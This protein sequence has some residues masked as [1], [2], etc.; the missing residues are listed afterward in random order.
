[1]FYIYHIKGKKIGCSTNV[2]HRIRQ[3]GFDTFEIIESHTDIYIASNREIE[4]Q[5][6]YGYPI[7]TIPYWKSYQLRKQSRTLKDI[8]KGG[9]T[10]GKIN[11]V[12]GH[13]A[14]VR[15]PSKGGVASSN[16][17]K[18]CPYCHHIGKMPS[19]F[20]H[21]YDNCKLKA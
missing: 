19:I 6:E 18:E 11:V 16:I 12:N 20:R 14:K 10:Q 17:T 3:Q 8:I 7:D 21:H 1:M 4:L 13:L 5:K 9:K 15:N 2:K